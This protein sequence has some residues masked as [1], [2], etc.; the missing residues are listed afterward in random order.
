MKLE[1]VDEKQLKEEL[2]AIMGR[3]LDREQ[4]QAFFFGSRVSDSPS[5]RAD[6]DIGIEGPAPVGDTTMAA[7]RDEIHE[8]PYL[9]TIDVVDFKRVSPSFYSNA[10]RSIEPLRV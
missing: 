6:I 3:H 9:Y 8:L 1:H 2:R 7:I 10:Q 4:Y 5:E